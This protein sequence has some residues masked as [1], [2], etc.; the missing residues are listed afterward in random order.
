MQYRSLPS[1]PLDVS[2]LGL[3]TM[4]FGEQTGEAEALAQLDLAREAGVN[5]LDTA[6]M[7]PVPPRQATQGQSE[8]LVG[9]WLSDRRCREEVI[10]ATKVTAP[11]RGL[12]HI[13]D[14]QLRLTLPNIR[15][16]LEG[17][18]RRLRTDRI[19]LYQIHWPERPTNKFGRR[20]YSADPLNEDEVVTEFSETLEALHVLRAEGKIAHYGLSNETPWGLMSA[21]QLSRDRGWKPIVSIQNPYNLLNRTFEESLSEISLL[22]KV[23]LL[24]YSPLAFGKLTG[25]YMHGH[26]PSK[27]RLTQFPQF[28]R[29]DKPAADQA[30]QAYGKIAKQCGLSLTHVSLAY[31][32][33]KPFVA[34]VLLGAS[35]RA[36]LEENLGCLQTTL[37]PEAL[38]QIDKIHNRYPSP[39]P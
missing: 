16:A 4:T 2:V 32:I 7:Y 38:R 28:D 39:C 18:L 29:Y 33:Q 14:G 8:H 5:L 34:S 1:A 26:R 21:R 19:D 3:G 17:S 35:S 20:T 36:Q 6:E 10:L 23:P 13:R 11:H 37:S 31:L 15:L 25:K 22:E 12:Q 24:A 9:K 30:L 27:A